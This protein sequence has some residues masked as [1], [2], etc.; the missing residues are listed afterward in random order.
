MCIDSELST[1]PETKHKK[2]RKEKR[3]EKRKGKY[4]LS[5]VQRYNK[6]PP[7]GRLSDRRRGTILML[8]KWVLLLAITLMIVPSASVIGRT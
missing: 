4:R 5:A 3:K 6:S 2:K 8:A 7:P 1:A